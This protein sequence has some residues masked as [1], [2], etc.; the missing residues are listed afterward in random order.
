MGRE[1]EKLNKNLDDIEILNELKI[2]EDIRHSLNI[3][4]I[5]YLDTEEDINECLDIISDLS[6]KYRNAHV[7][8]K[9]KLSDAYN[10]QY[11]NYNDTLGDLTNFIKNARKLLKSAR[12]VKSKT[13]ADQDK[14][15]LKVEEDVLNLKIDQLQSTVDIR[16][17]KNIPE[18]EN[19]IVKIK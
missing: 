9:N 7:V 14:D 5:D 2:S 17:G 3:F 11:P 13:Q 12:Q 8:L 16:L 10:S 18:L 4:V 19:Y 1:E 6:Q 15:A